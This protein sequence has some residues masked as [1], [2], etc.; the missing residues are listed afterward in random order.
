VLTIRTHGAII[1]PGYGLYTIV[2]FHEKLNKME[3]P[4]NLGL[5]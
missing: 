4:V 1:T 5:R 2:T 3:K